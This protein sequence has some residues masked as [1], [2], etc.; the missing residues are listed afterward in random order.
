MKNL[1]TK[2][3]YFVWSAISK[4]GKKYSGE[5]QASSISFAK[6]KLKEQGLIPITLTKK[7]KKIRH[8]FNKK[9]SALDIA[10]FFRQLATLISSGIPIVQSCE[11]LRQ[12]QE[13]DSLRI[14]INSIKTEIEA[15]KSLVSGLQNFP[16]HFDSLICNLIY[17]GEQTGTLEIMLKRIA[18]NKEKA[19]QF[20]NQIKQALFYPTLILVV[21]IMVTIIMLMFIVPRFAELFQSMHGQ[22]P[23]FTQLIVNLSNYLV[24]NIWLDLLPFFLG[25]VS[26]IYFKKSASFRNKIDHILLKIPIFNTI[27]KKIILARFTRSLA[28]TFAAGVP[29]TEALLLIAETSGNND[30][31]KAI[32]A[33][34]THI[35]SGQQLHLTMHKNPL[36][37]ALSVQMIKVGE[38]SGTLE[39]M[40]EKVAELYENDINHLVVNLSH[41]LEP[42][43]M[44]ILG[45]LIGS[46]VIAMYLPIFKLGTII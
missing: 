34:Q 2:N 19:L 22:L 21:A 4:E 20:K 45:V 1:L 26:V 14:L 33:L 36:F 13:K 44:I 27:L 11:I 28:I 17:A 42:L 5:I 30:Y 35:A 46:L 39:H 12:S 40:L 6:I 16:R 25:A 8:Y 3:S 15:G 37:P 43:I 31:T 41:S 7:R 32:I 18:T 23:I 38:E 9:I 29:I 10:L 24:E